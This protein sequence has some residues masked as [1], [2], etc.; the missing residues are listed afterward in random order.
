LYAL[1]YLDDMGVST[2]GDIKII[3]KL[4]E[5]AVLDPSFDSLGD[6]FIS[7][8]QDLD[9]Y[10]R[11]K[12][13]LG[14]SAEKTLAKLND[15]A[16]QRGK[17]D[18]FENLSWYSNSLLRSNEAQQAL[19]YGRKAFEG[20]S[21]PKEK[22]FTYN[23][24]IPG[25]D[26]PLQISFDFKKELLPYRVH[27]I[28]G[29]NGVGKTAFLAK[30]ALDLATPSM[31][32]FE[33]RQERD[34]AFSGDRPLFSRVITV[35]LSAFD[36]FKRPPPSEYMSYVYCGVKDDEN[37]VTK[38]RLQTRLYAYIERIMASKRT[39]NWLEYLRQILGNEA[40]L[41]KYS[42][43][44][45]GKNIRGAAESPALSS[46]QNTLIYCV[47]AIV[48]YAKPGALILFDEPELHLHPNAL[49]QLI[50]ILHEV[51]EKYDCHAILATHSALVLQEIPRK[52]VTLLKRTGNRTEVYDIGKETF[53]ED[54]APLT[55]MVFETINVE[56]N[57]K[58][59]LSQLADSK[60]F[61]QVSRLF[62]DRLSPSA[63]AYLASLYDDQEAG[64]KR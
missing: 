14:A 16:L 22:S 39:S 40:N 50:R 44:S 47:S 26:A 20:K 32:S 61:E 2:I 21:I 37:R 34:D 46:G 43:L 17:A 38:N 30:L 12:R 54:I 51:L 42:S 63:L 18:D 48:A 25:A 8:G 29:R 55:E 56:N 45:Q 28:I 53:G 33:K 4:K 9:F 59:V 19:I 24:D 7:L 23:C 5:T 11:A 13:V 1:E 60:S 6:E 36:E 62:D 52:R 15:I 10:K 27:A 57:Y 49:S 41:D 58:D 35:S 64:P 31:E 3:S